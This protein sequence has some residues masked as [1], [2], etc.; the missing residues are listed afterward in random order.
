MRAIML[1]MFALLVAANPAPAKQDKLQILHSFCLGDTC[2]DGLQPEARPLMDAHGNLYVAASWAID[3]LSPSK[4]GKYRGKFKVLYLSCTIPHCQD[5]SPRFTATPII[6]KSGN[7]YGTAV[8]GGVNGDGFVYELVKPAPPQT[9]WTLKDIHD[10]CYPDG[11]G[12]CTPVNN[13]GGS[14]LTY[15]GETRGR[16]YDG[17]SALY[18]T[19]AGGGAAGGGTAYQLKPEGGNWTATV[20]YNFCSLANCADGSNPE[21][22]LTVA[23]NGK[24]LGTTST[25]GANPYAGHGGTVFELTNNGGSWTETVLHSFCAQQFCADGADPEAELVLDGSGNIVGVASPTQAPNVLF[26]LTREFGTWYETVLHTFC[27]KFEGQQCL[28]GLQP[29]AP[30]SIDASGH[31]FGT[32]YMGGT[33]GVGNDDLSGGGTAFEWADGKF[34]V[35]R[36]FC[37]ESRCSDGNYPV[38]LIRAP[39]GNLL[40]TVHTGGDGYPGGMGNG[41]GAIFELSSKP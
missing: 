26:R 37:K 27:S 25:G 13:V 31:I 16:P 9:A 28:D 2:T 22:A 20:L 6:D 17:V 41:G 40:G 1:G 33:G 34:S 8:N 11:N 23:G 32:T 35:L 38:G 19:T 21:A 30:V 39:G 24:L 4:S 29:N 10:F 3:E 12:G 5:D 14:K 18:G 15:A 7:L 36:S